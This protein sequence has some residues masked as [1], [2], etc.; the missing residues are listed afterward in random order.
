MN[1]HLD[2]IERSA[3]FSYTIQYF[4]YKKQSVLLKLVQS[5]LINNTNKQI[6]IADIGCEVGHDIFKIYDM[7]S[8][9]YKISF[10]GY[11]INEKALNI[12]QSRSSYMNRN[13]NDF[14]FKL[15]NIEKENIEGKYDII[16]MSE[17]LEHLSDYT[18]VMAKIINFL[19]PGGIVIVST[20]NFNNKTLALLKKIKLN[21]IIKLEDYNNVMSEVGHDHIS[22]IGENDLKL[23]A[24][25]NQKK[26]LLKKRIT[27]FYG[28]KY[29]D[30][31][32]F[33][34]GLYLILDSVFD[35]LNYLKNFT[36]SNF[37]VI[38]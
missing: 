24:I 33:L 21:K 6:S 26:I 30:E 5:F 13:T 38:G 23:I 14:K 37:Y 1:N 8:C 35:K 32:P 36:Y 2:G 19:N 20:P 27:F 28:N 31:R 15:L 34:F 7:F 11:D 10:A 22:Q 16:L 12:A 17:I 18:K 9:K 4:W 25:N 29:F 3:L